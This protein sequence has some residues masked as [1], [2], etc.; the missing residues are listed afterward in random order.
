M[1]PSSEF[2]FVNDDATE[3]SLACRKDALLGFVQG[4]VAL[5][6]MALKSKCNNMY[7]WGEVKRLQTW[8]SN[9]HQL[10]KDAWG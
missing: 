7:S 10:V 9:T 5:G 1:T 4:C 8:G 3:P 2:Q 6:T